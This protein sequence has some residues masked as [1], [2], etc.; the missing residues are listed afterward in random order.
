MRK[1]FQSGRFKERNDLGNVGVNEK[2]VLK[3]I[4]RRQATKGSVGLNLL[5]VLKNCRLL[6]TWE[7]NVGF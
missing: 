1:T 4:L 7:R 5:R 2:I 3:L 6:S